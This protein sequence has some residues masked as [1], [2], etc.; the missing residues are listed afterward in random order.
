MIE[1]YAATGSQ[2][3]EVVQSLEP[4]LSNVDRKLAIISCLSIVITLMNPDISPDALQDCVKEVSQ[5]ICLQM[6]EPQDV[7]Q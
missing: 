5:F 2:I 6:A 1:S 4:V 3:Y 7:V